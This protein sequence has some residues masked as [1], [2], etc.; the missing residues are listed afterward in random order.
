MIVAACLVE[1]LKDGQLILIG[2]D[3][4]MIVRVHRVLKVFEPPMELV[5]ILYSWPAAP[6]K[7]LDQ[8]IYAVGHRVRRVVK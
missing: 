7:P 2:D 6:A 1:E 8:I 3:T 4:G 5:E